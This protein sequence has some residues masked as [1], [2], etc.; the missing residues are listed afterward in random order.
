MSGSCPVSKFPS[1]HSSV[2]DS[3][4]LRSLGISPFR[5]LRDRFIFVILG[6]VVVLQ[7]IQSQ[8]VGTQ[9][10]PSFIRALPADKKRNAL[11]KFESCLSVFEA[12]CTY[13]LISIAFRR[14]P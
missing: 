8:G 1:N 12:I 11:T 5:F 9:G 10:S 14:G 6:G 13:L 7:F 4:L 3:M 2:N